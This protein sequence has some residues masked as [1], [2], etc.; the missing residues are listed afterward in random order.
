MKSFADCHVTAADETP[1]KQPVPSI[2]Q[3]STNHDPVWYQA[4][5]PVGM[6]L[7]GLVI[8]AVVVTMAAQSMAAQQRET[9]EKE[10][11]GVALSVLE[12][13]A[14]DRASTPTPDQSFSPTTS[15]QYIAQ[16]SAYPYGGLLVRGSEG[17]SVSLLQ[18][19]L[20]E[21]G[22]YN[23]PIDGIYGPLTETAVRSFQSNNR[24][25]VDGVAG[26]DTQFALQNGTSG[27]GSLP[28]PIGSPPNLERFA[29]CPNLRN[30]G[31]KSYIVLIPSDNRNKLFQVQRYV[32][33]AF[34]NRSPLGPYIQAG[35]CP[36][37]GTADTRMRILRNAG[38]KDAQV[39]FF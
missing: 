29:S 31:V 21:L 8:P 4:V 23:A 15:V 14:G 2:G 6:A 34:I 22:F 7:M 9:F 27:G 18:Q 30:P 12:K 3:V 39:R 17:E 1:Q 13:G 16:A 35:T 24:L 20:R 5:R 26:S 37:R 36:N 28:Q 19:R 38:F 10:A 32:S 11:S 25:A 33:S